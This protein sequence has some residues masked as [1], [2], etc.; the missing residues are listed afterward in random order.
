MRT[1]WLRPIPVTFFL[2]DR[3]T[4]SKLLGGY[5]AKKPSVGKWNSGSP[6]ACNSLQWMGRRSVKWLMFLFFRM[7]DIKNYQNKWIRFT[8]SEDRIW[9]WTCALRTCLQGTLSIVFGQG[10]RGSLRRRNSAFS[11]SM[12]V[13]ATAMCQHV[14]NSSLALAHETFQHAIPE[15]WWKHVEASCISWD[16]K[17]MHHCWWFRNPKQPPRMYKALINYLSVG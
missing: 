13:D 15:T 4:I 17:L 7:D 11:V 3:S 2:L 10:W 8:K 9:T 5:G 16:L 1:L 12:C 6:V 14:M